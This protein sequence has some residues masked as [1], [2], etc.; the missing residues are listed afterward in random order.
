[1][2]KLITLFAAAI[3]AVGASAA[4]T[5][6][7]DYELDCSTLTAYDWS[8]NPET[9]T[10]EWNKDGAVV[11][12]NP[13]ALDP[14]YSLQYWLVSNISL[15][16]GTDYKITFECK[17]EGDA[18]ALIR[19]KLGDWSN[20]DSQNF[21][22]PAGNNYQ[23]ITINATAAI[24][25]NGLFFQHGDFVGKI[26][27]KSI[28]ITHS[29]TPVVKVE[30]EQDITLAG[31]VNDIWE[32]VLITS[33]E[34]PEGIDCISITSITDPEQTHT[35]Q[36]FIT[37]ANK[38]W[39]AGEEYKISFWYKASAE[40][41]APPPQGVSEGD[42]IR[43]RH[44]LEDREGPGGPRPRRVRRPRHGGHSRPHEEP[45]QRELQDHRLLRR[46]PRV[47]P[48]RGR[49]M[50]RRPLQD[51]VHAGRHLRRQAGGDQQDPQ[52]HAG[53]PGEQGRPRVR[54][55]HQGRVSLGEDDL[56]DHGR[57]PHIPLHRRPPRHRPM[58]CGP[59]HR[60]KVEDKGGVEETGVM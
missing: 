51:Q 2:K 16:A 35:T 5:D 14:W 4:E 44:R 39:A 6:N 34:G 54:H 10:T 60:H 23:N 32:D 55:R 25:S 7:V 3:M 20:G 45:A 15:E 28:K 58:Q 27:W 12:T 8:G 48:Q 17:A 52:G 29:G 40:D 38:T 22:I 42:R 26:Y 47:Q 57:R 13:E 21:T 43:G 33:K 37:T 30:K 59:H 31:Q 49:R 19:F 53:P 11:I 24:A 9:V 41:D 46:R 1:M 50:V 56:R 18:D 36:F